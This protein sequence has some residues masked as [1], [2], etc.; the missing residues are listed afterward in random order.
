MILKKIQ[1]V[2]WIIAAGLLR[3]YEIEYPSACSN[4]AV[5][6]GLPYGYACPSMMLLSD[7]MIEAARMDGNGDDFL[8]AVAGAT[9]DDECGACFQVRLL[10]AERQWRDDFPQ[11]II[12]VVNSGY[13][14]L[15]NQFDVYM[16]AGG[17]GYFTACN[18]DCASV[19]C[20]GG[21]CHAPMYGSPFEKWDQAQYA[22]PNVCYSGGIKWLD[23]KPESELRSLCGA[24]VADTN[25]NVAMPTL[26]SCVRSNLMLLHQNFVS[27]DMKRVQCPY[28]L[29]TL[30]GLR[31]SDDEG[32]PPV[33]VYHNLEIQCRGDRSMGHYC[34][35]TMQDC[36][37]FSCSW[38]N[39]GSP[40]PEWPR[41]YTC[42]SN[43]NRLL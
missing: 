33:S 5:G 8:Y 7:P 12:Q 39:K 6:T 4:G 17:F 26:D 31:R 2:L 43:G 14:V 27:T 36:C 38:R 15:Y 24:V 3:G 22:D 9:T 11:L 40:H 29:Y 23:Q 19:Y 30:T 21:G 16:G 25:E 41:V 42:D 18:S 10:D 1:Y 34:Y 37:K 35:T 13:D 20:Q 32:Y 28:H